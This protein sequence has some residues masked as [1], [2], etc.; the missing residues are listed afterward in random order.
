VCQPGLLTFEEYEGL[1]YMAQDDDALYVTRNVGVEKAGIVRV[2]KRKLESTTLTKVP[3]PS[4]FGIVT[5]RSDGGAMP[6]LLYWAR[7]TPGQL[8]RVPLDLSTEPTVAHA[9]MRSSQ[10]R[11]RSALEFVVYRDASESIPM[12]SFR[13]RPRW[14]WR[15]H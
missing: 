10:G 9:L 3:E 12:R 4:S 11:D 2:E 14:K 8:M 1:W 5:S 13:S 7:Q 15:M 6:N